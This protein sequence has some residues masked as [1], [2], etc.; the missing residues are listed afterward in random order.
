ML[1]SGRVVE[2]YGKSRT[3]NWINQLLDLLDCLLA[4]FFFS[5][6]AARKKG[7]SPGFIETH[8]GF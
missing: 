8:G 2:K 5:D 4:L 3:N 7:P 6:S 1:V